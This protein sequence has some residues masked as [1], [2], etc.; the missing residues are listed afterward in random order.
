MPSFQDDNNLCE[1][2]RGM[3]RRRPQGSEVATND[4]TTDDHDGTEILDDAAPFEGSRMA[5]EHKWVR[6]ML[7]ENTEMQAA[8]SRVLK[9][10][11]SK[12]FDCEEASLVNFW[13]RTA[14]HYIAH[15]HPSYDDLDPFFVVD[16]GRVMIQMAKFRKFLPMVQPYYAIKCNDSESLVAM[17]SALGGS[18]DCASQKEIRQILKGNYAKPED[19][20]FANPC[21]QVS[22][23]AF[24]EESGVRHVTFDNVHE[25]EKLAK[26][27]PSC[28]AVLRI[29]TSDEKAVCAFSTKFGASMDDVPILLK[30]AKE[31]GVQV[32]GVSFHVGSGNNDPTAYTQSILNARNVFD[33][34]IA[35]GFEMKLLDLGGGLPGVDPAIGPNGKPVELGFEEI[36]AVVAPILVDNFSNATIIAE[37]GRFFSASTHM[38]AVNVHSMRKVPLPAAFP[39]AVPDATNLEHQYYI[40]DGLYH[41]FNCIVFDHAH[42][43][44]YLVKPGEEAKEHISTIFGP[45]CDSLDCVLKRQ[46]FPELSI[47]DWL[48]VPS[49]GAYTTAAGAPFN[50]F[51]TRRVE[52]INS[53]PG[54]AL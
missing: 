29:K 15:P 48:F 37:P 25:V 46:P 30:R 52:Y 28:K 23:M 49:F 12:S 42:P 27:M 4:A 33:Q 7:E 40:N 13:R 38:L 45:T 18:Y 17:I 8:V 20:I 11:K 9:R 34:A 32:T 6:E 47:G 21:K 43:P 54:L 16:F 31:L 26:N 19:I 5:I 39:G 10:F 51:A 50:G 35:M 14:S 41:S 24:A 53:I 1:V 3:L 36:C 2:P 22:C 44:L